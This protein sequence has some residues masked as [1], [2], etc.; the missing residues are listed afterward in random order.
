M[1]PDTPKSRRGVE[2]IRRYGADFIAARARDGYIAKRLAE[3]G[4]DPERMKP[5]DLAAYRTQALRN[6]AAQM[7][8]AKVAKR[9]AIAAPAT[10]EDG[11]A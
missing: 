4:L 7:R 8:A 3:D 1:D 6:R 11:A 2:T 9:A 5:A 10:P